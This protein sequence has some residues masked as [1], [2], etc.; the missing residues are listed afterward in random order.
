MADSI[1]KLS[2]DN[3][4]SIPSLGDFAPAV[5]NKYFESY[6]TFLT[7]HHIDSYENFVFHELPKFIQS[8]NPINVLLD[9]FETDEKEIIHEYRYNVNMYIGGKSGKD[10]TIS[11]PTIS[12]DSNKTIRRMFPN[13]ARLRNLT[14]AATISTDIYVEIAIKDSI[15]SEP[16]YHTITF[17]KQQF[18]DL[19]ILLGSKL[20]VTHNATKQIRNEMGECMNEQGGYFIIDGSEKVLVT[21]QEQSTNVIYIRKHN[22]GHERL[23]AYGSV[24]CEHPITHMTRKV[25]LY[26]Q[27]ATPSDPK[28]ENVIRVSIPQVN[29]A[30][31]V[32]ILFRALGLQTD[33]EIVDAIVGNPTLPESKQIS[34][35][36][37]ES[38]L[39]A[40]PVVDQSLAFDYIKLLTK[41]FIYEHI[42]DLLNESVFSHVPNTPLTK[43][44][45]LAEFVR[46]LIRVHLNFDPE[47]DRDNLGSQRCLPAGSLIRDL[48]NSIYRNW[49][50]E[51]LKAIESQFN[52]NKT[53]YEGENIKNLIT[54]GSLRQYI[55]YSHL[56]KLDFQKELMAAFR[57]KW[58]TNQYDMKVGVLQELGRISYYDALS[59]TRR[60]VSDFDTTLKDRG[61]RALNPSQIGFLC[62]SESPTGSSHGITKNLAILTTISIASESK[63]LIEWLY[64]RGNVVPV[65]DATLSLRAN[66]TS[67]Q[68]NGG[69]IGFV[70]N[71]DKLIIAL[72][73]MKWT[74]CLTPMASISFNT[75]DNILRIFVDDGRLI[76][77]VYHLNAGIGSEKWHQLFKSGKPLPQW[78]DLLLGTLPAT[79]HLQSVASTQFIDV[80]EESENPTLDDYISSLAPYVGAIEY[81]DVNESNESYISW[82]GEDR[83]TLTY[84]H[85]HCEIHPTTMSGLMVNTLPF[86]NH[87][88]SVRWTYASAQSKQGIGYYATNYESRFD[89][90]GL[91]ACYA[92]SPICRTIYTDI[93]GNGK[94]PYGSNIIVALNSSTGYNQD[95][96]IILNRTSVERGLF[97]SLALRSYEVFEEQ[98]ETS[99]VIYRIANP[100]NVRNWTDIQPGLDYSMLDEEGIIKEGTIITDKTVLVGRYL[101]DPKTKEAPKDASLTNKV[102]TGGRVDKVVVIH[103]PNGYR[104]VKIRILEMRIPELGDKFATRHH[105]KGTIGMLV[106]AVDM[107]RTADGIV[108]DMMVNPHGLPTRMTVGQFYEQIFCKYGV[109]YNGKVNATNFM[110]SE[111]ALSQ[112]GDLLEMQ[113]YQRHGEEILYS[114]ISGDQMYSSIF[115][116]PCYFM[117]LKHLTEDKVNAREH[118]RREIRTHQPTGGRGNE[119][120]MKIGE[121]ERDVLIAHG[122]SEFLAESM[123]DKSDGASFMIC[124]GCGTIPVYNKA[125]N[126]QVC[127]LC[128]GPLHF[129][130]SLTPELELP[131]KK[132]RATFSRVEIPYSLKL[133]DQESLA[134][135]ANISMRFVTAKEARKFRPFEST[136]SHVSSNIKT[137]SI[138]TSTETEVIEE[139][140]EEEQAPTL[141]NVVTDLAKEGAQALGLNQ[142]LGTDDAVA[143]ANMALL[144]KPAPVEQT[145]PTQ[146][147][148]GP[149]IVIN[150]GPVPQ[151]EVKTVDIDPANNTSNEN[152]ST[153]ESFEVPRLPTNNEQ[154]AQPSAQPAAPPAAQPAAQPAAPNSSVKPVAR[155]APVPQPRKRITWN[156]G[157]SSESDSSLEGPVTVL[158]LG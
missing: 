7:N 117:R 97:H 8:Q 122:A 77:P 4:T 27:K 146:Q 143:K 140:L 83:P 154:P 126:L 87:D 1:S 156:G 53:S 45:Y 89:T 108:P 41:G 5:L 71:P 92:E 18:I 23:K 51:T 96:A 134:S 16:R 94:M 15:K 74:G 112:L 24:T 37:H 123:M 70:M 32:F 39:D 132:S 115:M 75:F 54:P 80:F 155:E 128:D 107:P 64:S 43:A 113:G 109:V 30:I 68:V 130:D 36:L 121:M 66:S 69:T 100:K 125:L 144:E 127:P 158:K 73:M 9:R 139:K 17:P 81:I 153:H 3:S 10:I 131:M 103:Q 11:P 56:N 129:S 62:T 57:G 59:H 48:F 13:E 124:N 63:P 19:P 49:R 157:G 137:N 50:K 138:E 133:M 98:D 118:G 119:G 101:Y 44:Q 35:F 38:I 67:V 2:C 99:K 110:D 82:Y 145:Q 47:T 105:Q 147:G 84:E 6:N 90:F 25:H 111:E 79:S 85:T 26:L 120:G 33:K 34:E 104:L 88:Q 65:V 52:Y 152:D 42:L 102:F 29:G 46:K 60:V 22:A 91:M 14:Y 40:Y 136:I 150:N 76:R 12:L 20:C 135:I 78:R 58:G 72:K 93:V 106:D 114:G 86:P 142:V 55:K 95:D 28:L 21:H 31:P 116:T 151:T 148:G 141:T 149:T 61:P